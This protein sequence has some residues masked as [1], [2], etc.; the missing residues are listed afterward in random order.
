MKRFAVLSG[1]V[2]INTII[3]DD[4]FEL[5]GTELI[6]TATAGPGW[7]Y[8]RRQSTFS[9]PEMTIEVPV[10]VSMRQA[11]LALL[12]AGLLPSVE[13]AIADAGG[14]AQIEW[15][16]ATELRRDHSLISQMASGLNLRD[17]DVDQLFVRAAEH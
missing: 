6:E 15:E 3:A 12:E 17:A 7:L 11:R 16:Y 10:S 14:S 8:D 4:E 1:D 13:A 9:P 2:V 5:Q